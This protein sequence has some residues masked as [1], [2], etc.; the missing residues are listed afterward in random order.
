MGER[1]EQV[2]SVKEGGKTYVN[3]YVVTVEIGKEKC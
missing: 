1:E 3:V 2:S